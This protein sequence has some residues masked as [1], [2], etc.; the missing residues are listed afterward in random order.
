MASKQ[1]IGRQK[2]ASA[3]VAVGETQ[4]H[5]TGTALA[6]I[7]KPHLAKGESL[8]DFTLVIELVAR[9]LDASQA[10]MVAADAAH[11]AELGDDEPARKARDE[12]A[13][14]LSDKLVE[15]R[16]I[17]T[18]VYGVETAR[19]VFPGPTPQDPVVLSRFA[20]EVVTAIERVKLPA[21][22]LKGA[23]VNAAE[24][25]ADLKER[26]AGLDA[27]LKSV[28]REVREAQTTLDE[29]T[30]AITGY[31]EVFGGGATMLTGLLR[32]AGKPELAAKVRPSSRRPG[33]TA[34]DAGDAAP[35]PTSLPEP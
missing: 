12:A 28:A 13:A 15:L 4:A 20:G 17:L 21:S 19:A 1:V 9:V 23:K 5:A 22:R 34:I 3:V 8:P 2:S 11:E 35:T 29:K 27:Q 32:L 10:T 25:A 14:E 33:Q 7:F 26:R 30:R 16:E 6:A 24:A 18:G 31:D